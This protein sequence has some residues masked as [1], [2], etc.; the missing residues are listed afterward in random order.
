VFTGKGR[1]S[2]EFTL[3]ELGLWDR[4]E[5]LVSS[6]DVSCP[7]PDPEGILRASAALGVP[8][9]RILMAGDSPAD[10]EAGRGAGART[11]VVLWS[12]FR[13]E[14]LRHAGA[15]FV[16]DQVEDLKTAVDALHLAG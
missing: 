8:A 15:D 3:A 10:V 14:R 13:P 2:A 12:A 4:I 16:C 9:G 1:R 5:L 7:K 11:A 6:D